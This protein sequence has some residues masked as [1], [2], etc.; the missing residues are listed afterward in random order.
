MYSARNSL[1]YFVRNSFNG[2]L[3]G[4]YQYRKEN[5][6]LILLRFQV[7][8]KLDGSWKPRDILLR[9]DQSSL[10]LFQLQLSFFFF[11]IFSSKLIISGEKTH[12]QF[13]SSHTPCTSH[14]GTLTFPTRNQGTKQARKAGQSGTSL[15]S[16]P[17]LRIQGQPPS[18]LRNPKKKG[19]MRAIQYESPKSNQPWRGGADLGRSNLKTVS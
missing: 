13:A 9:E 7:S 18:K 16:H 8:G 4:V 6:F 12:N 3:L 1:Q 10:C 14:N 11:L 17:T 5:P 2:F 19:E 15:N